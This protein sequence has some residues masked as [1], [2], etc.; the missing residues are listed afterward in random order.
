M[1]GKLVALNFNGIDLMARS[2]RKS[3]VL[4]NAKA[5]SEKKWKS[6]QHRKLRRKVN[7]L[8]SRSIDNVD[9]DVKDVSNIWAAPKDGKSYWRDCPDEF[10]RK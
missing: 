9:L 5:E 2:K 10:L 4:G 7:V 8:L 1:D 3:P 6:F